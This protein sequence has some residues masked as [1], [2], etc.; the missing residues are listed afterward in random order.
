MENSNSC[1]PWVG[2]DLDGTL[3]YHDQYSSAEFIGAPILEM[4]ERVKK[5]QEQGFVVKI[6][7]ARASVPSHIPPVKKWLN[8]HGLGDLEVTCSKDYWMVE[9]WDDRSIQVEKNTGKTAVS[10]AE[11][12]LL[13]YL[14][15]ETNEDPKAS[16]YIIDNSQSR[17]ITLHGIESRQN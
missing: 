5:W 6:L 14:I 2:V 16:E 9:L 10:V 8:E 4:V 3:A 15:G 11:E 1:K 13:S 7:T 12:K 17:D